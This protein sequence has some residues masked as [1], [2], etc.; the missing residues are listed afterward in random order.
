MLLC[1]CTSPATNN[2]ALATSTYTVSIPTLAYFNASPETISAGQK[3]VLKWEITGSTTVRISPE[4][5]RVSPA[6]SIEVMPYSTT[7]Y[8]LTVGEP[9]QEITGTVTITVV[10]GPPVVDYFIADPLEIS[11]GSSGALTWNIIGATSVSI[12]NN[13]G[14]VASSGTVSVAPATTTVYTL[15][16][17]NTEGAVTATAVVLNIGRPWA[18]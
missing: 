7:T 13:I 11:F 4:I 10:P 15:T 16:A 9:A 8:T 3:A 12:D 2:Q 14:D 6:G 5:G 17:T 1:S 18:N